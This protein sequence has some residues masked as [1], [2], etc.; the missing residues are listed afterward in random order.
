MGVG[1]PL[2]LVLYLFRFAHVSTSTLTV[3]AVEKFVYIYLPLK[4][5]N[6]CTVANAKRV[7]LVLIIVFLVFEAQW[8]YII[9]IKTLA[10]GD[11]TCT[12]TSS[13]ATR[14]NDVYKYID[15][16]IYSY[17]PITVMG[18]VNIAIIGK[19]LHARFKHRDDKSGPSSLSKA[20]KGITI[21]LIGASLLFITCTL[22]YAIIYE[23]DSNMSTYIY[24]VT[25]LLV[26]VNHS[27][28]I[29]VYSFTNNQF[30]K[31][32]KRLLGCKVNTVE[33]STASGV[34]GTTN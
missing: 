25:A 11:K 8:F 21:M 33:P 23:I 5:R 10:S 2:D 31:E 32:L 29:I 27:I 20:A 30:R 6:L 17:V 18:L 22:P 19:L 16:V 4:A 26:Y 13:T 7:M 12:T 24:A 14:Y 1:R 28:N 9:N 3:T 15:S 34:T